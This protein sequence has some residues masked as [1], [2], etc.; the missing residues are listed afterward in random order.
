MPIFAVTIPPDACP[1]CV[2]EGYRAYKNA[3]IQK[4]Y[5]IYL[6]DRPGDNFMARSINAP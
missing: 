3:D 2:D 5:K 1:S 6:Q 4:Y